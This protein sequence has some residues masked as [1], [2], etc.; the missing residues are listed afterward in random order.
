M[1]LDCIKSDAV[2]LLLTY[3]PTLSHLQSLNISVAEILLDY[4]NFYQTFFTLPE[5]KYCR[6][7]NNNDGDGKTTVLLPMAKQN[8]F[9][10]I[11]SMFIRHFCSFDEVETIVSYMPQLRSLYILERFN[12]ERLSPLNLANLTSLTIGLYNFTFDELKIYLSKIQS[13]LEVLHVNNRTE[14]LTYMNAKKW[15][16]YLVE[17]L[18]QLK[19]FSLSNIINFVY[20]EDGLLEMIESNQFTSSFWIER[21]MIVDMKI[22]QEEFCYSVCSYK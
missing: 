16:E 1:E 19:K 12:Y 4:T 9:S 15:E 20:G 7:E 5:L 13:Q 2:P 14:D 8:Q 3:L 21:K 17:N 22:F 11:Q 10:S 6:F 18:S